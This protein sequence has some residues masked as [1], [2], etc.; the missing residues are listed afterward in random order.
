MA[1]G[2]PLDRRALTERLKALAHEEGFELAGTCRADPP[3]T[4]PAFSEWLEKG[5]HAD[6]DWLAE[7]LPLRQDPSQLLPGVQSVLAVGINY[8]QPTDPRPEYPLIARY[9]LGRDYHKL[10]RKKLKRVAVAAQR[11]FPQAEFRACVDSAPLLEREYA[12]RAG[13]G[14][15]GKNTCLIHTKTGSWYL[16]GFLLTTLEL[17]PDA[18]AEGDCGT[19]RLCIDACPT[20]AIVHREGRWQ[21]DSR[22]CISYWTIEASGEIPPRIAERMGRWTFG[23]DICQEVCP[24]NKPREKAP[25][26]APDTTEPAFLEKREWPPLQQ[27]AQI[28]DEEFDRLTQGSPVRR[29]GAEGLRRNARLALRNPKAD[30]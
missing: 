16:L 28:S 3:E 2:A 1:T 26:R 17:E 6:M 10:L 5:R 15:P 12:Q 4:L 13:L 29:A 30:S 27:L 19:C 11:D 24:F 8:H 21:V 22:E 25:A 7:S 20:G 9:A 14:W 23:C 18:P